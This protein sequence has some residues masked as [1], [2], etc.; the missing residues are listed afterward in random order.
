MRQ[1]GKL[2]SKLTNLARDVRNMKEP[3]LKKVR[4][5]SY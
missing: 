5:Y 3:R 1:Q 4:A 2:M